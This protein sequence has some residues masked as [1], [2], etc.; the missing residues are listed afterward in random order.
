MSDN[1]DNPPDLE[2][3][4]HAL[5]NLIPREIVPTNT[6]PH[7]FLSAEE[8]EALIQAEVNRRVEAQLAETTSREEEFTIRIMDQMGQLNQSFSLLQHRVESRRSSTASSRP[9]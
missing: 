2:N 7:Q 3:I 9:R 1:E 6:E 8:Q 5:E 4:Q